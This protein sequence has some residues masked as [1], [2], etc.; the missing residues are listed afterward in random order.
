MD[1]RDFFAQNAKKIEKVKFC[2]SKRFL[3]N[4][5]PIEWEIVCITALENNLIRKN[6]TKQ[7][8]QNQVL[9]T[10][11]YQATL[12]A[13]CVIYP[14]LNDIDLQNSYGTQTAQE[15]VCTM[16]SAGEFEKLSAKV[17]EVNGFKNEEELL[18]EAKN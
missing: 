6:C 13:K 16:L 10:E 12:T 18:V 15:L 11:E 4:G 8:G 1:L 7:I 3:K 5:M 9:D 2:P 17:L 14:N